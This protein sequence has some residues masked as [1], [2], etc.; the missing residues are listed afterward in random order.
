M[1]CGPT[2]TASPPA[3]GEGSARAQ[4]SPEAASAVPVPAERAADAVGPA[5]GAGDGSEAVVRPVWPSGTRTDWARPAGGFGYVEDDAV[6][7]A[8]PAGRLIALGLAMVAAIPIGLAA[9]L[10]PAESGYGTHEQLGLAPCAFLER[11]GWPCLSC[12]MTT[13]FAHMTRLQVGPAM[14]AQ[15]MGVVFFLGAAATAV[16]GL[17]TA[18]TGRVRWSVLIHLYDPRWWMGLVVAW[19]AAWAWKIA[20]VTGRI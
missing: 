5:A 9:T 12:G 6:R 18:V 20:A 15:P 1:E 3:A 19:L 7:T 10:R 11:T 17:H 14:A 16:L 4:A 8:G 2:V 13:A